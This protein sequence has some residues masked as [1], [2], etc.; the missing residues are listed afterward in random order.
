MEPI[1]V[2]LD[3]NDFKLL[4]ENV[5][6]AVNGLDYVGGSL[7]IKTPELLD[8]FEDE[9]SDVMLDHLQ[10]DDGYFPDDLGLKLESIYDLIQNA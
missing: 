4:E 1:N 6:K 2:K 5:P 3:I 10:A 7:M 8:I 9:L